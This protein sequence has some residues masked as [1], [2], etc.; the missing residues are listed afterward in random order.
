MKCVG[1]RFIEIWTI[2]GCRIPGDW[3]LELRIH[4]FMY[5]E[6]HIIMFFKEIRCIVLHTQLLQCWR[7]QRW[8]KNFKFLGICISPRHWTGWCATRETTLYKFGLNT[9]QYFFELV[10]LSY[11]HVLRTMRNGICLKWTAIIA[12]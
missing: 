4:R 6:M 7:R 10:F 12:I 9:F 2:R 1:V 11:I 5:N 3:F 8:I